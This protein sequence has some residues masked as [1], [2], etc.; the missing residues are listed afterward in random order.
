METQNLDQENYLG[1]IQIERDQKVEI[2]SLLE[3]LSRTLPNGGMDRMTP[4]QI[5]SQLC[6]SALTAHM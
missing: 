3:A 5:E 6:T 1:G 4:A 2:Q